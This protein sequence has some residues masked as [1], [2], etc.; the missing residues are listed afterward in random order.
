MKKQ[1]SASF[2]RSFR[3]TT[4]RFVLAA[5][6]ATTLVPSMAQAP[7]LNAITGTIAV[8]YIG[9]VENQPVFQIEFENTAGVPVHVYIKD[10]EGNT[11]YYEKFRDKKFSKKFRLDQPLDGSIKLTFSLATEKEKQTQVF[12][13]NTSVRMVQ[14]VV[15]TKL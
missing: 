12:E 13:V 15:V 7:V 9:S 5:T 4:L 11:I 6:L 2:G 10:D 8:Q 3:N 14:D 1:I